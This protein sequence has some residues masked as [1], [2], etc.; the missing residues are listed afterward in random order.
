MIDERRT[1]ER[2]SET[3][4]AGTGGIDGGGGEDCFRLDK[5][6]VGRELE[7]RKGNEGAESERTL[8]SLLR[9]RSTGRTAEMGEKSS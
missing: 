5:N 9:G 6:E 7:E 8:D 3:I 1:D 4:F 2:R